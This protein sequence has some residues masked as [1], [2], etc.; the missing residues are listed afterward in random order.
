MELIHQAILC[1]MFS[2]T[3]SQLRQESYED[4]ITMSLVY[5]QLAKKNPMLLFM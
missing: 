4:L 1:K 2:C 3:P 5:E